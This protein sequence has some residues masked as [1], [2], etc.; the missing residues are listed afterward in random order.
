MCLLYFLICITLKR[1]SPSNYKVN[2]T[3]RLNYS[4]SINPNHNSV[5]KIVLVIYII[6]HLFPDRNHP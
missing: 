5:L 2:D 1:I 6:F 3:I 4:V